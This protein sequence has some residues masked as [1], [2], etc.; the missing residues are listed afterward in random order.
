MEDL[1]SEWV[2]IDATLPTFS[3]PSSSYLLKDPII[4]RWSYKR[5][6]HKAEFHCTTL[7]TPEI[8]IMPKSQLQFFS[9]FIWNR[10]LGAMTI[11]GETLF[12]NN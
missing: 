8:T 2:Q 10:L 12:L 4:T 6:D 1:D 7:P 11:T 9:I 5:T 3:L